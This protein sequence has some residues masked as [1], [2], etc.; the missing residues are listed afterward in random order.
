M[1]MPYFIFKDIDSTGILIVNKLPSIFK[2]ERDMELIPVQGRDGYLTNDLGS[3]RSAIK[4]VECTIRD[5]SDIDYIC[6]WLDGDGDVIFSNEPTK[7]YKAVIK[8]QIEFS[9]II[10]EF[11]SFIIQF[12]CQPHKYMATNDVITLTTSP[13]TINNIG[14]INSKPV[15]KIYGTGTIV[16][17][18]NGHSIMMNNVVTSV[19]LDSDIENAFSSAGNMNNDMT[20]EFQDLI[21]GVNTIS[22]TG[23][24]T[25]VEV[26]PNF[27]Y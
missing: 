2:P 21:P 14:M 3:Y 19:T 8:N 12:E 1:G 23:T 17:T 26:T 9:K 5:L 11:H 6:N 16:I 22:W 18:I 15:I 24:V 10:R 25:K 20:G 13:A 4:T 27:R 7:V